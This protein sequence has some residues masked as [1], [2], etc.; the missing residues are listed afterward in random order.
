MARPAVLRV[1]ILADARGVGRGLNDAEGRFSKFG[2]AAGKA[3]KAAGIGLAAAG[4]AAVGFAASSVRAFVEAEQASARLDDALARFPATNDKSRASF[5]KLNS[6]LALKTKFD[7]DATASGQAVLAQFGLTGAKIQEL[8]PLL[9]DYAAKTGKDLPD[10]AQDLGKALNGKGKALQAVGIQFKDAGSKSANFEQLTKGLRTQVGG[11]AEKEGKTAAGQV[12]ILK[13]R[14]GEVQETVGGALLPVLNKAFAFVGGT[15][16]PLATRLGAELASKLGP[17][18]RQVG[19]FVE[20]NVLPVLRTLAGFVTGTVIPAF[21]RIAAAVLPAL[22]GAFRSV[23]GSIDSNRANLSKLSG[24]FTAAGAVIRTL[25]PVVGS[26]LGSAFRVLGSILGGT[27]GVFARLIGFIDSAIGKIK[28]LASA[29]RNS[30]I[31]KIGGAIGGLFSAPLA[32]MGPQLV[33]GPGALAPGAGLTTASLGDWQALMSGAS[34]GSRPVR[35]QTGPAIVVNVT[36]AL[37]PVATARQIENLL[38][39]HSRR[40]G[41]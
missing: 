15:V 18:F 8:T 31:G 28:A 27:I 2:S 33:G 22:L 3:G 16:I 10:A 6:T 38:A 17:A 40:L 23:A 19:T 1:D 11:F 32:P 20:A 24:L 25:A 29:I 41:R 35:L 5:D 14:F 4:A 9:Q 21:Q 30:P 26:V 36:G 12:A 37:D 13:N 34:G 7:D 39:A